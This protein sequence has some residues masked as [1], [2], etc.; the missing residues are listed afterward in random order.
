MRLGVGTYNVAGFRAGFD[1]AA[2]ALSEGFGDEP[3][4]LVLLQ[5]CGS[6]AAVRRFA[7]ML[8]M[9]WRSTNRLFNRVQNAVL[10]RPPWGSV[11]SPF[12]RDLSPEPG[13]H[14]RGLIGVSVRAGAS[15][16]TAVS[17][18]LGLVGHQRQKHAAE[19][20]DF[21]GG[22]DGPVVMGVDL[23]EAPD[24]PATSWIALRMSDAFAAAGHGRGYTYPAHGP[25]ARIDYLFVSADLTTTRAWVGASTRGS[26]HRP[27]FAEIDIPEP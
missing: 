17:A 9:E 26:D 24:G 13:T 10:Y 25:A 15:H 2:A 20:M 5:E 12:I 22:M 7:R 1:A 3:P 18:H 6:R 23:N 16:L 4:Q 27:V 14:P 19:L 8:L 21:L 11:G